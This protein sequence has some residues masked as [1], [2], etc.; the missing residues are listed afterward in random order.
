MRKLVVTILS[1]VLFALAVVPA[2][3]RARHRHH[4]HTRIDGRPAKWCGWWLAHHLRIGGA[5]A[6]PLWL[7]EAAH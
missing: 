3:A 1:V 4:H 7:D 2:E 5:L 6:R